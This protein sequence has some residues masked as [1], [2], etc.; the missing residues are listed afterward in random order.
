MRKIILNIFRPVTSSV[1]VKQD[2]SS[3]IGK[4]YSSTA[5]Y[6]EKREHVVTTE[7]EPDYG[8]T[9]RF[10]PISKGATGAQAIIVQN[11]PN[12]VLGQPVEFESNAYYNMFALIFI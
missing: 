8:Y 3:S 7:K 5:T 11:I 4:N 9:S 6:N 2:S 12:G 10:L 1:S